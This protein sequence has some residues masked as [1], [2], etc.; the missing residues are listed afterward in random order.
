LDRKTK[1]KLLIARNKRHNIVNLM[2]E[3]Q[4]EES[5]RIAADQEEQRQSLQGK[6]GNIVEEPVWSAKT[7]E[8]KNRLTGKKRAARDRW[9]RFAGTSGGGGR[10]L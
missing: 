2:A 4:E 3:R 9:N 7:Q 5:A 8:I 10:G 1:K 6:P